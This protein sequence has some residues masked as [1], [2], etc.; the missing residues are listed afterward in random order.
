VVGLVLLLARALNL[1]KQIKVVVE[2]VLDLHLQALVVK[3]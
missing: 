1:V 3:E 2:Q